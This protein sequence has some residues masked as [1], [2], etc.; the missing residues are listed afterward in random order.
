MTLQPGSDLRP[1]A[2]RPTWRTTRIRRL[3]IRM[4]TDNPVTRGSKVC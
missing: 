4:A 1:A 3:V 2:P